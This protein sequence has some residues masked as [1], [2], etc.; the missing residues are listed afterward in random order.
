MQ[1]VEDALA[2][3]PAVNIPV[4]CDLF[5]QIIAGIGNIIGN[6]LGLQ[7]L[8]LII[9]PVAIVVLVI[10]AVAARARKAVLNAILIVLAILIFGALAVNVLPS[11]VPSTC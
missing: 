9:V 1:F 8:G 4:Q 5:N 6:I 7:N 2:I 3:L 11:F 10:V